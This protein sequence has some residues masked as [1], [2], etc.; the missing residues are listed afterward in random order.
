MVLNMNNTIITV[1]FKIA[2]FQQPYSR[3]SKSG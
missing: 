2:T 3:I 1:F